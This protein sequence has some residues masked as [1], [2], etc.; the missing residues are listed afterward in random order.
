MEPSGSA[1]SIFVATTGCVRFG[2]IRQ[3]LKRRCNRI[4]ATI[5]CDHEWRADSGA[6]VVR[7]TARRRRVEP[8]P[9]LRLCRDLAVPGIGGAGLL[10]RGHTWLDRA[11]EAG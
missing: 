6:R 3:A 11:A 2:A 7:E 5:R 4:S 10:R 9:P 8:P 1:S